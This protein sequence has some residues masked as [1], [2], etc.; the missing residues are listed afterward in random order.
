[1]LP[2]KNWKFYTP[3]FTWNCPFLTMIT[4]QLLAG[5]RPFNL[6]NSDNSDLNNYNFNNYGITH[7]FY[8]NQ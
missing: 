6:N 5:F 7:L 1:M 3:G 8:K 4:T 2:N